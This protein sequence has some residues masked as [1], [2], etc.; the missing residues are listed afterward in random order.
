MPGGAAAGK[1]T[2]KSC[3]KAHAW[4]KVCRPAMADAQRKEP[5]ERPEHVRPCRNCGMCNE[6]LGLDAPEGMKVCRKCGETLP[7][8]RFP[9]R[10]KAGH[11]YNQC[12]PCRHGGRTTKARCTECGRKFW[13]TAEHKT[14]C[15]RCRPSEPKACAHCGTAFVGSLAYRRYCSDACRDAALAIKRAAAARRVRAEALAAY[16]ATSAP[17]CACCGERELTFLSLDH[18][19]GGGHKQRQETGGGGFYAWLRRNGYPDGFQVLCHNCNLGR[20]ING[21]ICPH[22]QGGS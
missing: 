2:V 19:N 15:P 8:E 12:R 7:I 9:V 22:K 11:R 16:S 1:F 14:L 4:C 5:R 20:Q 18:V 21:G 10:D 6:C 17:S 13:E 3:G